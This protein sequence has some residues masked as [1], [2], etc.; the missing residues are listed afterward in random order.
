MKLNQSKSEPITHLQEIS[1]A[2]M[3]QIQGGVDKKCICKSV[4]RTKN[5]YT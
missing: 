2:Q 1:E 3:M 5:P 4:L